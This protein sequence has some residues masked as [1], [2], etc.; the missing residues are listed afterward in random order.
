[1]R[2]VR[3]GGRRLV[4]G[5]AAVAALS[6]VA[7]AGVVQLT[8]SP[9]EWAPAR[10][11]A[12]AASST[13]RGT[14]PTAESRASRPV[15]LQIPV[16]DVDTRLITLGLQPD[17]TIEVPDTEDVA[18]WYRHSPIPGSLGP[19]IIAGHVNSRTEPGVFVRLHELGRGDG[20]RVT[21][22]DGTAALFRVERVQ[23]YP[24]AA[25]PTTAVYGN[26]DHAGLRLITCGGSF[27]ESTGHYRD[28]VVVFASFVE[29]SSALG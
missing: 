17:G 2:A 22:A 1:M 9:A 19:A 5:L 20:V 15:R 14:P 25:F 4:L 3:Y 23:R 24:K 29:I 6:T 10:T 16:I 28:N 12:A 7:L 13:D 18:G 21:R 26:I 27:N 11:G 8:G